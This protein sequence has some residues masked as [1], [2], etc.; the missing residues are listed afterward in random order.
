[1]YAWNQLGRKVIKGQKGIRILAPM[2]GIRK[3]KDK[4]AEKISPGRIS[5]YSSAFVQP[6]FSM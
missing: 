4:E 6:T 2:I 3:K 5:P 1:M